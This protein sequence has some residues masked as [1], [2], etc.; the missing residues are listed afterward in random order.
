MKQGCK[1][2]PFAACD[3]FRSNSFLER[4]IIIESNGQKYN[5]K[6]KYVGENYEIK[7]NNNDWKPFSVSKCVEYSNRFTLHLNL[8]GIESTFS[9]VI[10]DNYID[11]FNEVRL[12]M[13]L[14]SPI[15]DK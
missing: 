9:A 4:S 3:G 10:V 12:N 13:I 11:I 2:L 1:G 7:I 15:D 8:N 5:I 6:I 14:F